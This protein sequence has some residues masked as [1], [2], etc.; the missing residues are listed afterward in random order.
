MR[1]A[2]KRISARIKLYTLFWALLLTS[3]TVALSVQYAGYRNAVSQR[4]AVESQ[5]SDANKKT[6]D[7][8]NELTYSS[9]DAFVEKVAREKLGLVMPGDLLFHNTANDADGQDA[10]SSQSSQNN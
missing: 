5:I 8:K 7:L 10:Q 2:R 1:D 6:A 3:F 4:M 9:S